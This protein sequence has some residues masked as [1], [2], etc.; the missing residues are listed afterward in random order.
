MWTAK[1]FFSRMMDA[2]LATGATHD[3]RIFTGSAQLAAL[4]PKRLSAHA[5]ASANFRKRMVVLPVSPGLH[6]SSASFSSRTVEIVG[7]PTDFGKSERCGKRP[8]SGTLR[9]CLG[10]ALPDA[11]PKGGGG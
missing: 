7:G 4:R 2:Q 1:S 3:M 5:P 8:R 10:P 9:R 6:I 11:R